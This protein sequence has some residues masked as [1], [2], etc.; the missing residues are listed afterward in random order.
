M[1]LDVA[2]SESAGREPGQIAMVV[3]SSRLTLG[4]AERMSSR[5]A[6]ALADAGV[7]AGDRVAIFM[8]NRIEAAIALFATLKAGAVATL[9][10]ATAEVDD[11]AAMLVESRAVALVT[12]SRFAAMTAAALTRAPAIKLVVLSGAHDVPSAKGLIRFET[13]V[14]GNA[15]T[16]PTAAPGTAD[17]LALILYGF[18]PIGAPE[19]KRLTHR[20]AIAAA[21]VVAAQPGRGAGEVI[22]SGR[23]VASEAGIVDVIAAVISGA[24]LVHDVDHVL[25]LQ[26]PQGPRQ[27]SRQRSGERGPRRRAAG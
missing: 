18:S 2:L 6:V 1:R 7:G 10:P 16:P 27:W 9:L 12:Q 11:L 25:P 17:D 15:R 21:E 5:L 19:T 23:P 22:L 8:D 14:A 26:A 3:G 4:A 13:A 24:T 20:E